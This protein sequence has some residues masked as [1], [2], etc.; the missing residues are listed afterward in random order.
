MERDEGFMVIVQF[1]TS[2]ENQVRALEEIGDYVA[3]FLSRQE[4]FVRSFLSR[5]TDGKGLV[6]CALWRSEADF[7]AAGAKAREHPSMPGLRQYQPRGQ[8]YQLWKAFDRE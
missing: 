5:S 1:D 6:H 2:P 8:R 3:E 4:G 7:D